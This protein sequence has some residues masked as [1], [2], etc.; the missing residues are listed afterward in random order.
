MSVVGKKNLVII[1]WLTHLTLFSEREFQYN[2]TCEITI[3]LWQRFL[4][5]VP[6]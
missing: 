3:L 1:S 4:I 2:F 6:D 5:L